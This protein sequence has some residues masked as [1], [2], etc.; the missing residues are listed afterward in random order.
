[1]A[2]YSQQL[3]ILFMKN[4]HD[5]K[6]LTSSKDSNNNE[7]KSHPANESFSAI[8]LLLIKSVEK[9]DSSI[10]DAE[11]QSKSDQNKD[12]MSKLDDKQL[13]GPFISSVILTHINFDNDINVNKQY[14]SSLINTSKSFDFDSN[15]FLNNYIILSNNLN[16]HLFI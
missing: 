2:I 6:N 11:S 3:Q 10:I 15:K 4:L 8:L 13:T 16:K 5:E 14:Q 12:T 9:H 7:L 1:M